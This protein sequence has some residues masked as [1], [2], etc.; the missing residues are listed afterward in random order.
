MTNPLAACGK[1]GWVSEPCRV[2]GSCLGRKGGQP[3]PPSSPGRSGLQEDPPELSMNFAKRLR[4]GDV[5]A[6]PPVPRE[7]LGGVHPPVW[8]SRR[9]GSLPWHS[10]SARGPG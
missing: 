7:G 2:E 6:G 5:G 1:V 8:A 9:Q 10:P 3:H 4:P